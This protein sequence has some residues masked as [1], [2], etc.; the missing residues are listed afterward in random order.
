MRIQRVAH[1]PVPQGLEVGTLP[2]DREIGC[3]EALLFDPVHGKKMEVG[4]ALELLYQQVDAVIDMVLG[5][6][7]PARRLQRRRHVVVSRVCRAS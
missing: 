3:R 7:R 6:A 4:A 1:T 5:D 2:V